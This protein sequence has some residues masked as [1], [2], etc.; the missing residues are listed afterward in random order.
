M[1]TLNALI[2]GLIIILAMPALAQAPPAD[3]TDNVTAPATDNVTEPEKPAE[4][5]A[6]A[7][8]PDNATAPVPEAPAPPPPAPAPGEPA[9]LG[10]AAQVIPQV[11]SAFKD[12]HYL[13]GASLLI[14][15][16]TFAIRMFWTSL[17]KKWAP[18]VAIGLAALGGTAASWATGATW[19]QGAMAGLSAG[20]GSIGM[21]EAGGKKLLKLKPA[22]S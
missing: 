21:Y 19:W 15:L 1:K 20:L 14:M 5:P 8:A 2:I 16:L 11:I 18:W 9:D 22:A 6:P 17:P 13:V 7:P 4:A 10:E 3:A 12:G